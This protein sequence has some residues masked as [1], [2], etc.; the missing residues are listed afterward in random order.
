MTLSARKAPPPSTSQPSLADPQA[1]HSE[2]PTVPRGLGVFIPQLAC[3]QSCGHGQMHAQ[4][5]SPVHEGQGIKG[6]GLEKTALLK[7]KLL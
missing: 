4:V 1:F 3:V 6:A 7:A 5:A 2:P